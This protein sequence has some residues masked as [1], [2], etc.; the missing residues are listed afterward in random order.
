[1][2]TIL[3]EQVNS[4]SNGTLTKDMVFFGVIKERLEFQKLQAMKDVADA[5]YKMKSFSRQ[6]KEIDKNILLL[7]QGKKLKPMFLRN[8]GQQE[9]PKPITVA[10][11]KMI[12]SYQPETTA[13]FITSNTTENKFPTPDYFPLHNR[14]WKCNKCNDGLT[15]GSK[16]SLK[17]HIEAR[18][19][20]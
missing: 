4:V 6:I 17:E 11:E 2:A 10:Q 1:M 18:H 5:K 3:E 20:Y 15:Y 19:A 14:Q 16:K 13:L 8:I 12:R 9:Q 7:K